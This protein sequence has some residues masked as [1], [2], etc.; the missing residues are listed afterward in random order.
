MNCSAHETRLSF[1]CRVASRPTPKRRCRSH[2]GMFRILIIMRQQDSSDLSSDFLRAAP[3]N[4]HPYHGSTCVVSN[5]HQIN[6][7]SIQT[8]TNRDAVAPGAI[9]TCCA[10]PSRMPRRIRLGLDAALPAASRDKSGGHGIE[11]PAPCARCLKKRA[12]RLLVALA[13]G[14]AILTVR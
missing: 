10:R 8:A 7:P 6:S 14:S 11:A 3:R 1:L 4:V 12:R 5:A 13:A 2:L 9:R